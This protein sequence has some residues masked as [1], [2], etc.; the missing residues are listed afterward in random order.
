M[1]LLT[2][3]TNEGDGDQEMVII[4]KTQLKHHI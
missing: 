3:S 2:K 1:L 4:H